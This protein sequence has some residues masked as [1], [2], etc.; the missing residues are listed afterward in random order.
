LLARKTRRIMSVVGARPQFIKLA[1]VH[2][3][4]QAAGLRHII[5]HTGQ[6]YN[7]AMSARFFRELNLPKA[8]LNLHVRG[9]GHVRPT[10]KMLERLGST[11][12]EI[13]P[14]AVI[15]Y[16]DTTTTL[17][18]A[19][20]GAQCGVPVAHIEAGLRSYLKD[21]P[22][23]RNR[24]VADH[25]STWLFA[26][27]DHAVANLKKEG[28]KSGVHKVGDPMAESVRSFWPLASKCPLVVDG[29]FVFATVHRAE[30]TDLRK[31]VREFVGLL[32]G[33]DYNIVLPLH[34]R[35]KR[36]LRE[37]N[38]MATVERLPNVILCPPFGYLET[39][40]H[41]QSAYAV[42]TDSGGV[43]REAAWLGTPCLT[44]RR[45]TE[46]TDTV[47]RGAN[48]LI[49]F[50]LAKAKRA[51]KKANTRPSRMQ[52]ANSASKRIAEIMQRPRP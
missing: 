5:V 48:T 27:T 22:E 16:G 47:A 33:L 10:A 49:D 26:P 41:I 36:A 6:H 28:I 11:M 46:W 19:L 51:L 29:P 32:R 20:A 17:A 35:T 18:A 13:K 30:N 21:Q 3:A 38:L 9:G 25:L 14:H 45:V 1:P 31:R 40:K 15:V 12:D 8:D 23:E 43:Q 24:L 34:P 50:D 39:L 44:M 42:L 37:F 7:D 2:N 4:L 52:S